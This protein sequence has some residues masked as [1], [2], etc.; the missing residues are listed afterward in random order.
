MMKKTILILLA[1]SFCYTL[2]ATDPKDG[3]TRT[4]SA[5]YE[6]SP[7]DLINLQAKYT[8]VVVE[9]WD[10]NEV[11]VEATLRF[12]GKI[13]DRVQRFL[14]SFEEEVFSNITEGPG[15]LLIKTNLDEPNKFQ[16]G[17]KFIGIQIDFNEDELKLEYKLK[18]PASNELRIKNSYRDLKL[19]GTFNEVEIDQYSGDLEAESIGGAELKLKYGTARFKS[20]QIANMELYEQ[21][22]TANTIGELIIDTKYSELTIEELGDTEIVSYETDFEIGTLSLLEGNLKYGKLE[23][24]E[25]LDESKLTT[26]EFDIEARSIGRLVLEESKYGKFEASSIESLRLIKSYEDDF[27]LEILGALR[28]EE[29][30]YVN[31][32][33]G[34]V[35]KSFSVTEGYEGSVDIDA[36]GAEVSSIEITGKYIDTAIETSGRPYKL[37]SNTKYGSVNIDKA[38]MNVT[39]YIQDG[40][41]LEIEASSNSGNASNP[42]LISI[43][44]YEIELRL[45]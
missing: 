20:I 32:K 12:D 14:D 3:E 9:A 1:F 31:Y 41:Q 17:T 2:S 22:L 16:L 11:F 5:T 45:D 38:D 29:S 37:V 26:Y 34:V 44:G 4:A 23:I 19:I 33:I 39:R 15:E 30:K 8:D 36:I 27:D 28:A 43:S 7:G 10:K 25:S 40:D 21:E 13:N 24:T 35:N 18:V 6:V 42:V